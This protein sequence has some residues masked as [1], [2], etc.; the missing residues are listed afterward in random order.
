MDRRG[1]LRKILL[2]KTETDYRN[3]S[4]DRVFVVFTPDYFR[5]EKAKRL[6]EMVKELDRKYGKDRVFPVSVITLP[7]ARQAFYDCDKAKTYIK[8]VEEIFRD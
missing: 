2:F 4:P 8:Q 3:D 1:N 5:H 7:Y 6:W